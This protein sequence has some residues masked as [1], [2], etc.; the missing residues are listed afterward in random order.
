MMTDAAPQVIQARRT[1]ATMLRMP[2]F[3]I[4][5]TPH[6][7]FV[8]RMEFAKCEKAEHAKEGSRLGVRLG[9]SGIAGKARLTI[10]MVR[11]FRV[12]FLARNVDD[13]D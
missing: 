1:M 12:P 11:P 3:D 8:K 10:E 13:C 9:P 5:T 6:C 4:M 2:T 7:S